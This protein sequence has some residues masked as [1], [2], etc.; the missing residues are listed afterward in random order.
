MQKICIVIN[1]KWFSALKTFLMKTVSLSIFLLLATASFAQENSIVTIGT[2]TVEGDKITHKPIIFREIEFAEGDVLSEKDLD[3]KIVSSRQNL[4]NRS[5]FNFVTITKDC[6]QGICDILVTVVERWYIWPVPLLEYADRNFNVWWENKDLSR[7]NYG[8]D[9]R[10]DN[11]RGRMET[12][13]IIVK[14]GYDQ[15]FKLKWQIPYLTRNQVLG[16]GIEG[17]YQLNHEIAYGTENNR[18]KFFKTENSYA[19]RMGF[20]S[21]NITFRPKFNFLHQVGLSFISINIADSVLLLN[22]TYTNGETTNNFFSLTY[23][24]KHDF[25][26]YKPYPLK[27]YYF[28]IR[29]SKNGLGMLN[30]NV[31]QFTFNVGIDHYFNIWKRWSFAYGLSGQMTLTDNFQPYF[32]AGGIGL[33][34]MEMRGYEL[35]V[36]NGQNIGIVKSNLKFTIIP[37]TNLNIK[38]IKT[39]KFGK[40][41]YSLHANLFFDMG[42][43]QDRFWHPS[44]PLNNQLL[45]G[46]GLGIDL[47]TYYDM[48]LRLEYTLNRQGNTGL[49]I[50]MVAPI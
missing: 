42:Y 12:L 17:G 11:F 44:N 41:F 39:D 35:Y 40:L 26:D 30:N 37:K 32:I 8:I 15:L 49:Y 1:T 34:G 23:I 46:T 3:K 24:Y 50:S 47:V 38:W 9:L 33:Y 21:A 48:V 36:I 31:N 14:G 4:L 19:R 7:L 16:L 28:E 22:P 43:A 20:A 18:Y 27:G 13:N 45:W 2:I 5:L 6:N 25:R 29:I 10:V